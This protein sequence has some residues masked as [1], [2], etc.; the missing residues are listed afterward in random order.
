MTAS[1]GSGYFNARFIE[2]GV[3]GKPARP[4]LNPAFQLVRPKFVQRLEA[5]LN[6]AGVEA[7]E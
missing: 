4:F 2:H 5:A 3:N 6:G 7:S 1:I